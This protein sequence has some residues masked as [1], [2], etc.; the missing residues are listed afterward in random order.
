[1]IPAERAASL[2]RRTILLVVVSGV[3]GVATFVLAGFTFSGRLGFAHPL[4]VVL[5][6]LPIVALVALVL[7]V[8]SGLQAGRASART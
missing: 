1:M 2:W 4:L 8:V 3:F 6:A 7:A 5:F